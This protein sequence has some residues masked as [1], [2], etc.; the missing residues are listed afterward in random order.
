[1]EINFSMKEMLLILKADSISKSASVDKS[2]TE[3]P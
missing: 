3:S 2:A 1:M